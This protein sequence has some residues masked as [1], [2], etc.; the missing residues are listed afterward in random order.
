MGK[1]GVGMA[2][3]RKGNRGIIGETPW[4]P[5]R[6]PMGPLGSYCPRIFHESSGFVI[7]KEQKKTNIDF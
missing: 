2:V 5:P 4:G 1:L 6:G 3:T 7:K